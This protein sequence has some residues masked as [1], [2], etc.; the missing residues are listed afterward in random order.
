MLALSR[1]AARCSWCRCC[2]A[3]GDV[4]TKLK[5]SYMSRDNAQ[6]WPI[7]GGQNP[8]AQWKRPRSSRACMHVVF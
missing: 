3:A 1:C 6:K 5:V 7:I 2:A 4:L 8:S